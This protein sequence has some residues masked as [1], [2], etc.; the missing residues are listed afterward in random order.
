MKAGILQALIDPYILLNT[1]SYKN[2]H[3]VHYQTIIIKFIKA[4]N[5]NV[6]N[7]IHIQYHGDY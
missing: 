6:S 5:V 3:N 1:S 4:A 2:V 7:I